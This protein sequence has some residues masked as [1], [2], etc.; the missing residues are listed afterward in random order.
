MKKVY[1][2]LAALL[3]VTAAA[4]NKQEINK[5]TDYTGVVV[6]ESTMEPIAGVKVSVTNG[7]RVHTST[8]TDENGMFALTVDFDKITTDYFLMLDG[9]PDLPI[10]KEELRGMGKPTYDYREIALYNMNSPSVSTS[11][12]TDVYAS[13]ATL[14]GTVTDA[15]GFNITER[16]VCWSTSPYPTIDNETKIIGSGLGDFSATVTELQKETTYYVRAYAINSAGVGY[17]EDV[18]FTTMAAESGLFSVSDTKKVR[19]ALGNL[20]YQASTNTW[21][22]AE[23]QWDY[24]GGGEYGNVYNNGIK[25]DNRLI[26]SLYTGWIDLFGWGTSGYDHG[27][28]CYQPW[29]T[30]GVYNFGYYNAY[31]NSYMGLYDMSGK[32]DWGYNPISNGGNQENQWRTLTYEEWRYVHSTRETQSGM[33]WVAATVNGVEGEILLPDN[34]STSNY[35]LHKTMNSYDFFSNII[36]ASDWTGIL[37]KNGAV[38]FPAAGGRIGTAYCNNYNH[39]ARRYGL[40]W[41]SSPRGGGNDADAWQIGDRPTDGNMEYKFRYL[42]YSVR[43]VHDAQ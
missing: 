19:F 12:A 36:S 24:V 35:S 41:A 37:E 30:S 14:G 34:W 7:A 4:C 5:I 2:I 8:R 39:S 22:F 29:S 38:F 31:G 15:H 23:N 33:R 10:R 42:G 28:V 40:Y 21:R 17:G 6:E 11:E 1:V 9:S 32:A 16:G 27:A 3:L 25:C 20:Q 43:L 13:S 26:D 18:V